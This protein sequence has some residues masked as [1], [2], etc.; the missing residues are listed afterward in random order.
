MSWFFPFAKS[1]NYQGTLCSRDVKSTFI[2]YPAWH[3]LLI[4]ISKESC[5]VIVIFPLLIDANITIY[6]SYCGVREES[7]NKAIRFAKH[8]NAENVELYLDLLNQTTIDNIG[9]L[10]FWVNEKMSVADR[11]ILILTPDYLEVKWLFSHLQ[12][13]AQRCSVKKVFLEIL[14][15]S[16]ENTCARVSFLIKL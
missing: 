12:L 9:G 15:N 5:C 3:V 11:I 13:V 10:P 7:K 4:V 6:I 2:W 14:Q 1:Q 16:Q 8:L